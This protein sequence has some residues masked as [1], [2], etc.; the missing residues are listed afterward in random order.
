MYTITVTGRDSRGPTVAVEADVSVF[1]VAVFRALDY[2]KDKCRSSQ[3]EYD[4]FVRVSNGK[5]LVQ[6][7]TGLLADEL[8][9]A[10][11]RLV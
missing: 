4:N 9:F 7:D 10:G 1:Y 2:D 11:K 8:T 3:N 6:G 5:C